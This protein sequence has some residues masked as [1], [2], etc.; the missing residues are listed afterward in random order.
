MP[1]FGPNSSSGPKRL[2][3]L[4]PGRVERRKKAGRRKRPPSRSAFQGK[5]C[6]KDSWIWVIF[7]RKMIPGDTTA[8]HPAQPSTA[9]PGVFLLPL[10]LPSLRV[11]LTALT[12]RDA[13]GARSAAIAKGRGGKQEEAGKKVTVLSLDVNVER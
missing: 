4:Q 6:G 12:Q 3:P 8:S 1:D 11:C 5:R 9:S 13:K 7:Y 10:L 2:Q